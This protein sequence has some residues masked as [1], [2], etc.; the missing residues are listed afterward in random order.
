MVFGLPIEFSR[1][2]NRHLVERGVLKWDYELDPT[3][4]CHVTYPEFSEDGE[5]LYKKKERVFREMQCVLCEAKRGPC[6][7]ED[8]FSK[9]KEGKSLEELEQEYLQGIFEKIMVDL[10]MK[11]DR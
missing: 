3:D 10:G 9:K 6:D 11:G 2:V 7:R 1:Q 4:N 5:E 8:C